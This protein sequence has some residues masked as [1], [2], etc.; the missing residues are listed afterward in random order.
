MESTYYLNSN[1]LN[2]DFIKA[3]K[4][5]FKN[6]KIAIT[7][8]VEQSETEYLLNGNNGSHLLA[9][10]Q[11]AKTPKNL[12]PVDIKKLMNEAGTI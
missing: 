12:I 11:N 7:V 10:M 4:T 3:I 1:E 6:K 5:L 9:A 2:E 8:S